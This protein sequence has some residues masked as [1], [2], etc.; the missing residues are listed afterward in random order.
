MGGVE[1]A[2]QAHALISR[3]TLSVVDGLHEN[4]DLAVEADAAAWLALINGQADPA[5][6]FMSGE[7]LVSGDMDLMM[8]LADLL[9]GGYDLN[10]FDAGRWRLHLDY[11]GMLTVD[12][13]SSE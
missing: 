12:L 10:A 6:L 9:A 7:L 3:G 11:L 5:E 13:G 8:R 2:H 4:P 1:D